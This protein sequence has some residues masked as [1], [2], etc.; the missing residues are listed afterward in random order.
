MRLPAQSHR[1]NVARM[2]LKTSIWVSAYLRRCAA[3]GLGVY[4]ARRGDADAGAILIKVDYLDGQTMVYAPAINAAD[5][6][7]S[8]RRW[9]R[10][11]GPDPVADAQ[12]E[13]Q[14][15]RQVSFDQ[16]IWV[17][18]VENRAGAVLLDE[19]LISEL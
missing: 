16:D 4:V 15:A 13:E 3:Q 7:L 6:E 14:I 2:R 9:S 17:V 12:A 18:V 1:A 5:D 8:E 11:T 19:S 10:L